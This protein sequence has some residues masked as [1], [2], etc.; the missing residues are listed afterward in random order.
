MRRCGRFYHTRYLT[1]LQHLD[2]NGEPMGTL[3]VQ[4]ISLA[5]GDRDL[6]KNVSFT[7]GAQSR[8]A[9]AGGNGSG[10]STLLKIIHGDISCDTYDT[11]RS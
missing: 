2:E 5:Y 1:N 7:L 8:C 11:F 4:N 10:K 9:L 3:Q 6:L